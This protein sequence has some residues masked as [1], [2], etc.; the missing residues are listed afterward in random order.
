MKVWTPW[1]KLSI[2]TSLA[3]YSDQQIIPFG[4]LPHINPEDLTPAP[5]S[6][7]AWD[8]TL[9]AITSAI[10]AAQSSLSDL[11]DDAQEARGD[12]L[13]IK[14]NTQAI[15]DEVLDIRHTLLASG[16]IDPSTYELVLETDEG[17]EIYR[18]PSLRGPQGIQGIQGPGPTD[19]QI[20]TRVTA[21]APSLLDPRIDAAV[22]ALV[23]GAP[24]A[25]NQ[26][27][28]LATALGNDPSFAATIAGALA[29]RLRFD[30]AQTLTP[31]QQNQARANLNLD[32]YVDT[33]AD[34]RIKEK[35]GVLN[36][37]APAHFNADGTENPNGDYW[38][39]DEAQD[40]LIFA[41]PGWV[42]HLPVQQDGLLQTWTCP[43]TE[44]KMQ[45]F[46]SSETHFWFRNHFSNA[47][48]WENWRVGNQDIFDNR[49]LQK[50]QAT[51]SLHTLTGSY[52]TGNTNTLGAGTWLIAKTATG[53]TPTV[54][55]SYLLERWVTPEGEFSRATGQLTGWVWTRVKPVVG[56]Q[57]GW[58]RQDSLAIDGEFI[59][60]GDLNNFTESSTRMINA[61]GTL[62]A[63]YPFPEDFN[64]SDAMDATLIVLVRDYDL[65]TSS[66][67]QLIHQLV[68][69]QAGKWAW[70]ESFAPR[71]TPNFGDW[72]IT[73]P[74]AIATSAIEA[75]A[76]EAAGIVFTDNFTRAD[77]ITS[78]GSGWTALSGVWGISGNKATLITNAGENFAVRETGL[79]DVSITATIAGTS[80]DV[81]GITFRA[82]D[83]NNLWMLRFSF[84]NEMVLVKRVAGV[85]TGVKWYTPLANG[86]TVPTT[87]DVIKVTAIGSAIAVYKNGVQVMRVDDEAN[88]SNTKHGLW[89]SG[90]KAAGV[91]LWDNFTVATTESSPLPAIS[92]E[93]AYR[94]SP[95]NL[96]GGDDLNSIE[97]GDKAYTNWFLAGVQW[98][99][100][101]PPNPSQYDAILTQYDVADGTSMWRY[102]MVTLIPWRQDGIQ[103]TANGGANIWVREFYTPDWTDWQRVGPDHTKLVT[104]EVDGSGGV[105]LYM[106]GVEL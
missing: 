26:L 40:G 30:T 44:W 33:R 31:T 48:G 53:D 106:N 58:R 61:W 3:G 56:T 88:K 50:T 45:I 99:T 32:P 93:V 102:Q 105:T 64:E 27:N 41:G 46:L 25:L 35:I 68:F 97:T 67:Q 49:Y 29:A 101:A 16:R 28:E 80:A 59:P 42:I 24:G 54:Y 86:D 2:N 85:V 82:A 91:R 104:A 98:P 22:S 47:L 89:A 78:L 23:N 5:S 77:S 9:A 73:D 34:A 90:T 72:V 70:R 87:G 103:E 15:L 92:Q 65:E 17:V 38:S 55:E 83:A 51:E 79:K 84:L 100:N 19:L 18:S 14:T 66:P 57:L 81:Q 6:Q 95:G 94:I 1:G 62:P 4:D 8:A 39:T 71:G 96:Y 20:D 60:G 13:S 75:A 36:D 37:A 52:F 21:L 43:G 74:A 12:T 7:T 63:H 11:V 69:S 10:A 76:A